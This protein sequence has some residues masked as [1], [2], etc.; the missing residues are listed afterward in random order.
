M[1][2]WEFIAVG[3]GQAGKVQAMRDAKAIQI[4]RVI[5]PWIAWGSVV[6][7]KHQ[8]IAWQYKLQIKMTE[9]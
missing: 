3:A 9:R 6:L 4:V 2:L 7:Y 1:N 5:S 8:F